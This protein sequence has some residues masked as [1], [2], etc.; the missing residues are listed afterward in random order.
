MPARLT[1]AGILSLVFFLTTSGYAQLSVSIS[2]VDLLCNGLPTGEAQANPTGGTSP[3]TYDWSTGDDTRFIDRLLAGTYTVTVTDADG[4]TT[5]AS[6]TLSEPSKL[7]VEL[8]TDECQ[9][10]TPI[11]ASPSGGTEP[12]K[13]KW[14]TGDTTQTIEV[15]ES[16]QYCV[17][18]TDANLCG[19][20]AC[21]TIESDP[22]AI[23]LLVTDISCPGFEDGSIQAFVEGGAGDLTYEWSTGATTSSITDISGGNYSVTVTD[24]S[25]CSDVAS[26]TVDEPNPLVLTFEPEHPVCPGD[27]NGSISGL[28]S[29]GTFPYDYLWNTGDSSL[30]LS[31]VAAGTYILTVTDANGCTLVDS[32]TLENE[33]NLVLELDVRDET[34]PDEE[35][36]LIIA[37]V[38]GGVEPYVYNWSNEATTPMISDLAPGNYSVTVTDDAGCEVVS[39]VATIAES[40]DFEID[41]AVE[42]TTAPGAEDGSA[43]VTIVTGTGP[44]TYLWSTDDTTATVTGLSAGD[45]SVTVTRTDGCEAT[46]AITILETDPLISIISAPENICVGDSSGT[47]Q[48]IITGGT[49]PYQIEW[50][51][52]DTATI[53]GNLPIGDYSVTVTDA[54]EYQDSSSVTIEGYPQPQVTLDAPAIVCGGEALGTINVTVEGGTPGY[55]YEWNTGETT[56]NLENLESGTYSVTVTDANGCTAAATARIEVTEALELE[57]VGRNLFCHDDSTG[58]AIV[59]V[60]GGVEP[61]S[62]LWNTGDTTAEL[63]GLAAG[64]YYVTV[65]DSVLCT[66]TDSILIAE[67]PAILIEAEVDDVLCGEDSTGS[68]T[69]SVNGGF[70]PY[71]YDWNTGATGESLDSLNEGTYTVTVTDVTGCIAVDSFVVANPG[72]P[73]CAVMVTQVVSSPLAT[74]GEAM[75]SITGGEGPYMIEWSNGRMGPVA[76]SLGTGDYSVT[77]TDAN[78]CTTNCSIAITPTSALLG[79]YVWLDEDRDGFQDPDEDG[80]PGIEVILTPLGECDSIPTDTTITDENGLY[81]FV[82]EPCIYKLTFVVPNDLSITLPMSTQNRELDS[83][84]DRLM[85]MTDTITIGQGETDLTWDAGLFPEPLGDF[86]EC[87]CLDNATN[88]VNG[89]F[90][91]TFFISDALTGDDWV[92]LNVQNLFAAD[93]PEPP[94]APTPIMAGDTLEEYDFGQYKLDVRS[95][96]G[97]AYSVT[98]SNGIDTVTAGGIC[99]YP[100]IGIANVPGDTLDLCLTGG[101]FTLDIIPSIPGDIEILLD[102]VPISATIDPREL[103]EGIYQLEINLFPTDESECLAMTIRTIRVITDGCPAKLGDFVWFDENENGLQDPGEPGV[104]GIPVILQA[105][106]GT[107]LDTAVTD[108]TGMYMFMVDAGDY[109]LTFKTGSNYDLTDQNAGDDTRDSDVDPATMMTPV[110]SLEEGEI[111]LTIDAGLFTP[112]I[113]VTDPGEIGYD[114]MLC[115]P[116]NDPEPLVSIRPATG[117]EGELEYVWMYSEVTPEFNMSLYQPIPNSNSETYDPGPLFKTTYF[118]RCARRVGCPNFLEPEV[119][120]VTVKDDASA[121]IVGPSVVCYVDEVTYRVESNTADPDEI[122]WELPLGVTANSTTGEEITLSFATYGQ[123]TIKV[124][125]TENGCTATGL[126]RIVSTTNPTYCKGFDL[127]IEADAQSE[128]REVM[129]KWDLIE[130]GQEYT[131]DV[132]HSSDGKNF[133]TIARVENP[134]LV[135]SGI[136]YYEYMDDSPKIGRNYYRVMIANRDGAEEYSEVIELRLGRADR[137]VLVYPNPV[138]E[139]L[140]IEFMEEMPTRMEIELINANGKKLRSFLVDGHTVTESLNM[141]DLPAGLYFVRIKMSRDVTEVMKVWKT[142]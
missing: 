57:V 139:S 85:G 47:A 43:T 134:K 96:D 77:V 69:L 111:N 4:D 117:G 45:Y 21:I 9:S 114:Q 84:I 51:T 80:I 64:T 24:E 135:E 113:N 58:G 22:P 5:S 66:A 65:T 1:Y 53:I 93:S 75:V 39:E 16:G 31:N 130:D 86:G 50:S 81:Q 125:V 112:C 141:R 128:D 118:A 92:V 10:P 62:F 133:Q 109:K 73:F 136:R 120:K 97:Q 101:D 2:K 79:D 89:Q 100:E 36:G 71:T 88:D 13:Y 115:A 99:T 15:E 55:T 18:V 110:V 29:G 127:S 94:A 41:I 40:P 107:P 44:F 14:T 30:S 68:I 32:M 46:G 23:N 119:V 82:V 26:A 49:A 52:G 38:S 37:N 56:E 17:T 67:P 98:V 95:V 121:N 12:Y 108:G 104:G 142:E 28:V 124:H 131:F 11:S 6:V 87:I 3:Y 140:N 34:C 129:V 60:T 78:G 102:G 74:D 25:G 48:V 54:N 132:Q 90:E 123:Y 122:R 137:K 83:N 116:G 27:T 61:L 33:S 59:N 76:D 138:Q 103:G 63:S 72:N 35:D 106:D 105:P 126:K 8:F 7:N 19:R 20:L 91:N 70:P 42:P